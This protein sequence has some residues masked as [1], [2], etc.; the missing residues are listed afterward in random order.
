[1]FKA[2]SVFIIFIFTIALGFAAHAQTAK[3]APPLDAA[4][5]LEVS[6]DD[7]DFG[8]IAYGIT[9]MYHVQLKNISSD[10]LALTNIVVTCGCTTPDYKSGLYPPAAAIDLT[11]AYDSGV[12]GDFKKQLSVLLQDN[13]KRVI[14][15]ILRFHGTSVVEKNKS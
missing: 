1:M 13:Q 9:A 11:V 8:N 12:E 4:K 14:V 15:K 5:Y 7:H 2:L 3:T 6:D 10:T